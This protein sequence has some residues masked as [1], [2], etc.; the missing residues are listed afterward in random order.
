MRIIPHIA[1]VVDLPCTPLIPLESDARG[2][3]PEGLG[4][5]Q[6]GE[7]AARRGKELGVVVLPVGRGVDDELD[8]R[9]KVLRREALGVGDG[10]A[11]QDGV[12]VERLVGV[13]ARDPRAAA[14]STSARAAM[15][16]PLMPTRWT[17]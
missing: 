11:L 1:V 17:R 8:V 15:P 5:D 13:G 12:G 2:Q 6:G 7:P 9:G 3:R 16:V 10:E 4:I 14:A